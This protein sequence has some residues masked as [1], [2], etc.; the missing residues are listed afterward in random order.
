MK[1]KVLLSAS[2]FHALN[3]A[4]SVAVPMIFPV[5]LSQGVLLQRYTHIGILSNLGLLVSFLCQIIIASNAHRFEYRHM[6]LLSLMGISTSLVL[7]TQ[8]G[9]FLVLL[10]LY[11]WMRMF[12]SFYHPIGISM[13]SRTHPD[14]GLDFAIGIQSGSGN[15]GVLAAFVST[16]YL[17]Q[18]FGWKRPLFVWAAAALV[19]GLMSFFTVRRVRT[20][21]PETHK[22]GLASWTQALADIRPYVLG[23]MFGGACWGTTVFYAP[24]LLNH[25]YNLPLGQ[26]GIYLACWMGIGTLMTYMFGYLSR[27]IGRWKIC[28]A[29]LMGSS[30]CLLLLGLASFKEMAVVCLLGFG[31]FLFLLYPSLQAFVGDTVPSSKQTLAFGLVANI[32]MLSGSLA[33]LLAGVLSDMFGINA[34]FLFLAVLGASVSAY[35]FLKPPQILMSHVPKIF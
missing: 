2:L 20:K 5:L 9:A 35:Y 17:A 10:V 24:S 19:F 21:E 6:L 25:R 23:F 15:L 12:L 13:V 1:R 26:T 7:I 32:Q 4:A 31:T 28:L 16:G 34:P 33:S 22:L 18:S 29:G 3:D 11:L 8:S 27:R 14:R 30:L